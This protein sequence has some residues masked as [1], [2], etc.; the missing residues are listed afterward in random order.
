MV[1]AY[2]AGTE[3]NDELCENIP[4]PLCGGGA[5]SA[6]SGEGF[7]HIANGIHGIGDLA[8]ELYDWRNPVAKVTIRR[9]W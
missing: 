9:T 6:E 8:P 7:V 4:G 5:V 1:P 2:D 3:L